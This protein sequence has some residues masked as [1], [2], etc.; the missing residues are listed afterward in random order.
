VISGARHTDLKATRFRGQIELTPEGAM[1]TSTRPPSA[2][3]SERS[4][5]ELLLTA[6][7]EIGEPAASLLVDAATADRRRMRDG[8]RHDRSGAYLGVR[9]TD[10]SELRDVFR[11]VLAALRV[12][13]NVEVSLGRPLSERAH[14]GMV[15]AGI[16][17]RVETADR[18]IDRLGGRFDHIRVIGPERA[19]VSIHARVVERLGHARAVPM[20]HDVDVCGTEELEA[21]LCAQRGDVAC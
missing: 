9:A 17:V 4:I 7:E 12:G 19:R 11:V 15:R 6:Q 3:D 1:M 5:R 10:A 20:M 18:W 8:R 14:R 13:M 16:A 21:L 2:L